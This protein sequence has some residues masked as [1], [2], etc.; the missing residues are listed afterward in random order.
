M[1]ATPKLEQDDV[2]YHL[3]PGYSVESAPQSADAAWPGS[4][5]AENQVHY[6]QGR[7]LSRYSEPLPTTSRLL[8]AK[9]IQGLH[10]FY[11]KVAAADQQQL[12][13]TRATVA[14]GD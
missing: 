11:Q 13:L 14:K 8:T 3:P 5:H 6:I 7:T 1:F 10:D 12:V 4:R 9:T 2:T